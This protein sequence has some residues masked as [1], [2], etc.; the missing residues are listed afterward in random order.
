MKKTQTLITLIFITLLGFTSYAQGPRFNQATQL[1]IRFDN[2]PEEVSWELRL[3]D[4]DGNPGVLVLSS[5]AYSNAFAGQ[6]ITHQFTDGRGNGNFILTIKDS[7]NNGFAEG[8]AWAVS[9][10]ITRFVGS[11]DDR[12]I[13]G[14][15]D[16]GSS[17]TVNFDTSGPA[18]DDLGNLGAIDPDFI[19]DTVNNLFRVESNGELTPIDFPDTTITPPDNSIGAQ[20]QLNAFSPNGSNRLSVVLRSTIDD[21]AFIRLVNI[22]TGQ[23]ITRIRQRLNRGRNIYRFNN[24]EPGIYI[25]NARSRSTFGRLSTRIVVQ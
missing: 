20:V 11:N 21:I 24:L 22:Q 23:S 25:V 2:A 6:T 14:N 9:R 15:N 5:P 17:V 16:F 10:R 12:L 3:P 19:A 8:A 4:S 7:G 13:N 18:I 1:T